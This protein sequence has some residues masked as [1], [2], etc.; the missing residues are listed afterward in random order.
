MCTAKSTGR[1]ANLNLFPIMQ[2]LYSSNLCARVQHN[3]IPTKTVPTGSTVHDN[4]WPKLRAKNEST[5]V[6]LCQVSLRAVV[7]ANIPSIENVFAAV[8]RFR[9][10]AAKQ[11][12]G[13]EGDPLLQVCAVAGQPVLKYPFR[14]NSDMSFFTKIQSILI[15]SYDSF[16]S[17]TS[18]LH[19][20]THNL[21]T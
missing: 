1:P 7:G 6:C 18:S 9:T 12:S 17:S 19:S 8:R 21:P 3:R 4:H 15:N 20:R 13:E 5:T 11:V 10:L 14:W 16:F 2:F